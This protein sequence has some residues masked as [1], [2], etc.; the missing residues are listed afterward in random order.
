MALQTS[1]DRFNGVI[2]TLAIKAPCIAAQTTPLADLEGL[3]VVDGFATSAGDRI[4]V[5]NQTDPIE[6]GIYC[7]QVSEW[8]RTPD[9]DGNR[10]IT[11]GTIVNVNRSVGTSAVYEMI[12]I[13][14][15][16]IGQ[17]AINFRLW[18]DSAQSA[19]CGIVNPFGFTI[20]N[21]VLGSTAGAVVIDY[22]LGQGVT[23]NLTEDVTSVGFINVCPGNVSQIELDIRQDTLAWAITWPATIKWAGGSAPDISTISSITQVHLRTTNGGGE[24]L[25]T[26]AENHA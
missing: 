12:T 16:V 7:A 23:L 4:L 10:D 22:Q 13:P 15:P 20:L 8:T 26:F 21:Q 18:Y 6:N 2:A 9:F 3:L 14:D 19:P 17:D 24:W 1:E 25:G 11:R 5:V